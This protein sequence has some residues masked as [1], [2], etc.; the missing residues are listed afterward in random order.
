MTELQ[1]E[2]NDYQ[3]DLQLKLNEMK[4]SGYDR[5]RIKKETLEKI[6]EIKAKIAASGP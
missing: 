1:G 5:D 6:E 2:Q 4:K 3:I